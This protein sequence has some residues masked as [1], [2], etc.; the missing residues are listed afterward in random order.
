VTQRRKVYQKSAYP[1]IDSTLP[2][3]DYGPAELLQGRALVTITGN[4]SVK[5]RVPELDVRGRPSPSPA[6]VPMPKAAMHE[7]RYAIARQDDVGRPR[8]IQS[9][10]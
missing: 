6:F 4:I 9:L 5:F 2:N 1:F 3:G 10:R 7:D 8:Q